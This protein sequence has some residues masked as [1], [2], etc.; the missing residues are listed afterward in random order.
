MDLLAPDIRQALEIQQKR[1]EFE[2]TGGETGPWPPESHDRLS[3]TMQDLEKTAA[4]SCNLLQLM[5]LHYRIELD[6]LASLPPT[7]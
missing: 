6:R 3:A 2:P 1:S 4:S 5:N 7:L